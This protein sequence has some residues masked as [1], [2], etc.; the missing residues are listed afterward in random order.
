V[1]GEDGESHQTVN[2]T[3]KLSWFESIPTHQIYR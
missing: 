2:L 1:G 3:R